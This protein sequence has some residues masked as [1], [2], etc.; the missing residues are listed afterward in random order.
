MLFKC[1]LLV[2]VFSLLKIISNMSVWQHNSTENSILHKKCQM[3]FEIK[4][5]TIGIKSVKIKWV[6]FGRNTENNE[7]NEENYEKG[8][9]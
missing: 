7:V 6:A 2:A 5:D 9:M 8:G 1:N 3:T 4:D